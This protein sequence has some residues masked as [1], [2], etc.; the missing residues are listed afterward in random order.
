M[1]IKSD[2]ILPKGYGLAYKEDYDFVII[3]YLIPLNIIIR[4]CRK[5]YF[6]VA[7]LKE[8]IDGNV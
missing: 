5:L 4:F 3:C 1:R 6:I 7:K 8:D 2:E